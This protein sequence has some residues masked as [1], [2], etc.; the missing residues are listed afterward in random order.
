MGRVYVTYLKASTLTGQTTWAQCGNTTLVSDFR[1]RVVLIHKLGQL[2]GTEELFDRSS[3]WLGIDQI[4]RHQAFGFCH[5]ETFLNGP[6]NTHQTN[7]E[8][9]LSHFTDGTDTTVTQM[10][11]VVTYALAVTDINQRAH[12]IDDVFLVQN[13]GT[14]IF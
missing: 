6:L 1:E 3:H 14:G 12:N 7:T 8:L 2:A 11:D 4:L 13:T 10:V 5:G 9:V